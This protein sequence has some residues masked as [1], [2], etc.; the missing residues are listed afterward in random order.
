MKRNSDIIFLAILVS[1]YNR[2]QINKLQELL[3]DFKDHPAK[4][5]VAKTSMTPEDDLVIPEAHKDILY[6]STDVSV[7]HFSDF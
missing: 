4:V 7:L 5:Y 3:N 6:F 2:H 1:K